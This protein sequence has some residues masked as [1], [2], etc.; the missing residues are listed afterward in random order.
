[1][2][3]TT[4]TTENKSNLAT[5]IDRIASNYILSMN[6]EDMN[7]LSAKDH[8]DKLMILTAKILDQN[9]TNLDKKK[10]LNG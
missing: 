1:M 5:E 2:G 7:K 4:S 8:C 3:N 9:L 10:W 6:Y